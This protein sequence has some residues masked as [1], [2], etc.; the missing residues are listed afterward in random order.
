MRIDEALRLGV[1]I[2]PRR[3]GIPHPRR[4]ARWLLAAAWGVE[5][6]TL[7]LY[8]E[9]EVPADVEKRFRDWLGRRAAGEPAHHLTGTCP[10][11]GRDF[12]VNPSVLVPRPET[13]LLVET[14][15]ALP[16][17]RTA[18]VLDVGTGSGSIAA[19]LAAE[20]PGWEVSAV[21]RSPAA[22]AVAR[23]NCVRHRV[24]VPLF[25]GDLCSAVGPPWDLV[26]ANLPYV[27]STDIVRLPVEV[28]H[29]PA[30][31]L[32][33]GIDG[34]DLLRRLLGDLRRLVRPCGGAIIE[35][36]D[37]QA[38]AVTE[39]ACATGLAVARSVQDVGGVERV[40]VLQPR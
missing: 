27:R 18:K 38:G 19:T 30:K 39:I 33:G 10:F 14:A 17:S 15:L 26:V 12:E 9:R 7:R 29:D 21:D 36:G 28:S 2:L 6:T 40:I 11:W 25:V 20:R 35:V 4:E 22:L 31:A 37:D 3:E 5:E 23:R 13:E 24:S 1:E 34:L 32:D 8:P 16:L